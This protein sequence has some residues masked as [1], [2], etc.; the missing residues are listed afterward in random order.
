MKAVI[1]ISNV[2]SNRSNNNVWAVAITGEHYPKAHCKSAF[3]AMRFAF[4]LKAR[5]GLDI[6]ENCLSRL[7]HEISKQK[8]ARAAEV[9]EKVEE[10]AEAHSVDN[11]LAQ[12]PEP[13]EQPKKRR[14][15]KPKAVKAA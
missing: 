12:Q 1:I 11:V 13:A 4:L 8:A 10:F 15:R 3:K 14:G 5:T 7:S 9:K 2:K 6:S